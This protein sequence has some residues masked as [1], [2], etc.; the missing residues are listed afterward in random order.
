MRYTVLLHSY[1][2][3]GYEAVVPAVPGCMGKGDTRD[4]ALS[5][6][7]RALRNWLDRTEITSIDVDFPKSKG[8]R[9]NPWLVTAGMFADDPMSERM[10]KEIYSLRD[11]PDQSEHL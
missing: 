9:Q 7:R 2:T 4:E 6:L 8:D 1:P 5:R 10:L 3:G 11:M